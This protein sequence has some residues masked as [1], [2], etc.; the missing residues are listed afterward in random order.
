VKFGS[1][2]A[3]FAWNNSVGVFGNMRRLATNDGLGYS[4]ETHKA[5]GLLDRHYDRIVCLSDFQDT[6]P[7]T[8]EALERYE[9]QYGPTRFYQFDLGGYHTYHAHPKIDRIM[10]LAGFSDKTFDWMRL[11]EQGPDAIV[12]HIRNRHPL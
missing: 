12:A 9:Q 7:G 4:T 2:A 11:S 10:Y 8:L 5:I 1:D 3:V 6:E